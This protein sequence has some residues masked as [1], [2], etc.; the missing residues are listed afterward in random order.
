MNRKNL[1]IVLTVALAATLTFTGCTGD[2]AGDKVENEQSTEVVAGETAE[3]EA[4]AVVNGFRI[5]KED[6][7]K[8]FVLIEDSYNK[9]YGDTIWT[10]E[11]EGK[12]MRAVIRE[13]LLDD[14]IMERL[15]VEDVE[16]TGFEPNEEEVQKSYDGLVEFLNENEE[17][18]NFYDEIGIDEGFVKIQIGKQFIVDQFYKTKQ[19]EIEKD[20]AKLDE[21]FTTEIAKV[22]ASHILVEDEELA[23]E[24]VEK[25][26]AGEEFAELAKE[27]SKDPGSAANGGALGFFTRGRMV[28]EFENAAFL[29]EEG[30]I[31]EIVATEYGYHIILVNK[32][33]TINQIIEADG[34]TTEVESLK[35]GVVNSLLQPVINEAQVALKETATIEKFDEIIKQ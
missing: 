24:L 17:V 27:H 1:S 31:S 13:Q 4:V 22:D 9:K 32:K 25:L 28:P 15:I 3:V 30:K 34:E 23:K 11:I 29:T 7:E 2:A 8:N 33:L 21:L 5:T 20:N 12:S 14:M 10:Q 19:D 16:K 35:A 26:A 6:Y 18:K